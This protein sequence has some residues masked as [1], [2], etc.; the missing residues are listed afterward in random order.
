MK[1]SSVL[2]ELGSDG[3]NVKGIFIT[4]DPERDTSDVLKQYVRYFSEDLIGLTGRLDQISKVSQQYHVNHKKVSVAKG[5]YSLDHSS[6][7]FVVD[8]QGEL[9]TIVPY[10]LPAEHVTQVVRHLLQ[11]KNLA[12]NE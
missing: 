11:T 5:S 8:Q 9:A 10:G 2:S 4:L 7:L 12:I 3:D 1:L 6:N